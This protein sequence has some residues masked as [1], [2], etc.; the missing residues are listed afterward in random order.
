LIFRILVKGH[1]FGRMAD[2]GKR[3]RHD[4]HAVQ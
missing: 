4:C 3:L 1:V 2:E